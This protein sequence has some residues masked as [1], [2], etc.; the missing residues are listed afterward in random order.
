M[1]TEIIEGM[2]VPA[3]W[4]PNNKKKCAKTRI[5]VR[6][7]SNAAPDMK[8]AMIDAVSFIP[9]NRKCGVALSSGMDSQAI[10]YALID[11]GFKPTV[12]SVCFKH[13]KGSDFVSA[14]ETADYFGLE[15]IP[16]YLPRSAEKYIH[17]VEWFMKKYGLHSKPTLECMWPMMLLLKKANKHK[18]KYLAMGHGGDFYFNTARST[19]MFCKDMVY[20]VRIGQFKIASDSPT[21]QSSLLIQYA[22]DKGIY[23]KFPFH[24][25]RIYAELQNCTKWEDLMVPQKKPLRDAWPEHLIPCKVKNHQNMQLGD[26]DIS[27]II[28]DMLIDSKFNTGEW[29]SSTGIYNSLWKNIN[30]D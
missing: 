23:L 7:V 25:A 5:N 22:F 8:L 30:T 20:D 12:L 13:K 26:G 15:F 16:V 18:I 27:T 9:K 10:L 24:S 3:H 6:A 17:F 19:E 21:S 2:E 4:H 29:K 1:K 14:R 28:K 11:R